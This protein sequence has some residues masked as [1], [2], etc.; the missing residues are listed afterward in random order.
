[1][2]HF[3]SGYTSKLAGTERGITEP[4]AAFSSF[5]G[6]P[7]MPLKPMVYANLL[8]KKLDEY[9]TQVYLLNTGWSGGPYGTGKRIAI[10]YS[11]AMATAALNGDL[12]NVEYETHPIFN[13]AMPKSCPDVPEEVLNPRNTWEDKEAY[14]QK[15]QELANL[16]TKNCEQF[17]GVPEEIKGAG[18][19]GAC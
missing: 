5:F 6:K 15:A 17:E 7:F 13:L 2:Y 16:F 1:M 12:E 4:Q 8:G 9:G 3:I 11:R 14:D 19:K 18:P 10:K